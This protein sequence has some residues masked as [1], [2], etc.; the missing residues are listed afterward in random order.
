MQ[1]HLHQFAILVVVQEFLALLP[2][3]IHMIIMI[4]Q[5]ILL[6][7]IPLQPAQLLAAQLALPV[8]VVGLLAAPELTAV[9]TCNLVTH[10]LVFH[11]RQL[12]CLLAHPQS[13]RVVLQDWNGVLQTQTLV[14]QP[15]DSLQEKQLQVVF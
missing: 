5:P 10:K 11:L 8:V 9:H 2:M 13:I 14:L 1:T 15:A 6:Q 7:L 12:Q 3:M 4:L